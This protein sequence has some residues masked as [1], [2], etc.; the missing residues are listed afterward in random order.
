MDLP[1]HHHHDSAGW[2]V[3]G[4]NHSLASDKVTSSFQAAYTM[5]EYDDQLNTL[6]KENF[7]LKL[8]IYFMEER[9]G[10]LP[11]PKEQENI[12][13]V[14][15]D[16]KVHSEE[17]KKDL[18]EKA[19][20]LSQAAQALQSQEEKYKARIGNLNARLEHEKE[21]RVTAEK[22]SEEVRMEV[23]DLRDQKD[24]ER[25]ISDESKLLY[26]EAFGSINLGLGRCDNDA[27]K[28]E[29]IE[30][31]EWE[32]QTHEL[33]D[34]VVEKNKVISDLEL[35]NADLISK[36]REM[37]DM[38]DARYE[39]IEFKQKYEEVLRENQK[40]KMDTE[41]S[42]GIIKEFE[43]GIQDKE[44][45]IKDCNVY[46]DSLTEQLN[47]KTEE[48]DKITD[49]LQ[50]SSTIQG[51]DEEIASLQAEL[52]L[53]HDQ[54]QRFDQMEGELEKLQWFEGRVKELEMQLEKHTT[55][56]SDIQQE[57]DDK[58]SNIENLEQDLA[59]A[60]DN[61]K[62]VTDNM[63]ECNIQISGLKS[64]LEK[65]NID[66]IGFV[67]MLK[68]IKESLRNQGSPDFMINGDV[69]DIDVEATDLSWDYGI[70]NILEPTKNL[71][72][73][74]LDD[75]L[76]KSKLLDDQN[77]EDKIGHINYLNDRCTDLENILAEKHNIIAD[78]QQNVR[79][80]GEL[81]TKFDE[82]EKEQFEMQ[83]YLNT[84]LSEM[85]KMRQEL[86]VQK[87]TNSVNEAKL[88]KAISAIQGFVTENLKLSQALNTLT[89]EKEA[90]ANENQIKAKNDDVLCLEN[91]RLKA[92]VET[93][94]KENLE[95]SAKTMFMQRGI[96]KARA[97]F[98]NKLGEYRGKFDT[99]VSG[100]RA[101]REACELMRLR[102]EELADFLQQLLDM[103]GEGGDLNLSC[104]SLDMRESLQRS[105]DESRLLSASIL[106][107]Q[108]SMLQEMSM[109]GL[110]IG[111]EEQMEELNEEE[112]IVPEV[113]AS[114]F[115]DY[116]GSGESKETVSKEE[117]DSLLLELR[118]NLRKRR[119][120]EEE[121]KNMRAIME[122]KESANTEDKKDVNDGRQLNPKSKLP[123]HIASVEGNRDRSLTPSARGLGSSSVERAKLRKT[124]VG[125]GT[126]DNLGDSGVQARGRSGSRSRVRKSAEVVDGHQ[127]RKTLSKIPGP[128]FGEEEDCWSEPD[129]EES[130]RRIGL[131]SDLS[132]ST[133][134]GR[135]GG[136]SHRT[137]DDE[138]IGGELG[139]ELRRERGRVERLR[140]DLITAGRKEKELLQALETAK[141]ELVVCKGQLENS[142]KELKNGKETLAK[143]EMQS[144]QIEGESE[145]LRKELE[146]TADVE[147]E[148][149][150]LENQ[151]KQG[152]EVIE[153]LNKDIQWWEE[154][155]KKMKDEL[156]KGDAEGILQK[157]I[158]TKNQEIEKLTKGLN[159]YE[160][161]CKQMIEQYDNLTQEVKKWKEEADTKARESEQSNQE[162]KV[163]IEDIKKYENYCDKL[164]EEYELLQIE[165]EKWKGLAVEKKK[166]ED[167]TSLVNKY[168]IEMQKIKSE[169]AKKKVE[170]E[171]LKG[172]NTKLE[173]RCGDLDEILKQNDA[174]M[175]ELEEK[176]RIFAYEME[177]KDKS[178]ASKDENLS[179]AE[180]LLTELNDSKKEMKKQLESV[181]SE[182]SESKMEMQAVKGSFEK[183]KREYND[184][185]TQNKVNEIETKMKNQAEGIKKF[186]EEI[187]KIEQKSKMVE[188]EKKK[189]EEE[190]KIR[191][192][193]Q[194]A[195]EKQIQNLT[196][197]VEKEKNMSAELGKTIENLR[198]NVQK[199]E[200]EKML[201]ESLEIEFKNLKKTLEL[202]KEL[203][204]GLNDKIG[205][206]E[207]SKKLTEDR[208]LSAEKVLK[209][210]SADSFSV[211]KENQKS[212]LSKLEMETA[213][214]HSRPSSRRQG[215][216]SLDHNTS[217]ALTTSI[218][219]TTPLCC[220]HWAEL[221]Q[222]KLERDAALAKLSSTRSSLATTA[223]KLSISNRRKKQ[224]E[225]AI[226]QQLTKTHE[227]LKKTKNN[228]ENVGGDI[229]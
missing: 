193:A 142:K 46:I 106:A 189:L 34:M 91:E 158:G 70:D 149:L 16:L 5:R 172:T 99:V 125:T 134:H 212:N 218:P 40:L 122:A 21:R 9:L 198:N 11:A 211:D 152:D 87:D 128:V 119:L 103:E 194:K 79:D 58:R 12:Y 197:T 228:L 97:E 25:R 116:D 181:S 114:L 215:L 183:Y 173:E 1:D 150:L 219:S 123:V 223:E 133:G 174:K 157:E 7:N 113:E 221:E 112:W 120:A 216:S 210:I 206:L 177:R 74:L 127:R 92:E 69:F 62:T 180:R 141:K 98:G 154:W 77:Q 61:F 82:S 191:L 27:T 166:S 20:L 115:Y 175:F 208:C 14:N 160:A 100:W 51:R 131:E 54:Q 65:R 30:I 71:I 200:T 68:K 147:R 89:A 95:A 104:L 109:V 90:L 117:Y 37:G 162:I 188:N 129:K 168:E 78:L 93:L 118:D 136:H 2:Q 29:N 165:V 182:L 214:L 153:K 47:E 15:I 148:K 4:S 164:K 80:Q 195:S 108:T 107:S 6:K 145:Q 28:N 184:E 63:D 137:T 179:I 111:E 101:G 222:V 220:S 33:T 41:N 52:A 225:K 55:S 24:G 213:L 64:E 32:K 143:L 88:Q 121:L 38:K 23:K 140:G 199:L 132:G 43:K 75:N 126:K 44:Y 19:N 45:V 124:P 56:P 26:A 203:Q 190:L 178:I 94:T 161:K 13:R 85:K 229:Q 35:K 135:D 50:N 167:V 31:A 186:A 130:R 155:C 171:K 18:A 209:T 42:L 187:L 105:I 72:E 201:K 60:K 156:E 196:E 102:L 170:L 139:T 48:I 66:I 57:L 67:K 146:K 39:V 202:E 3:D 204:K 110:Q 176:V 217:S 53:H 22:E 73:K 163:L 96:E 83:T 205:K 144:Q 207:K 151:V 59:I 84:K 185:I 36:V 192:G 49:K 169:F 81:Q 76:E 86:A 224:V 8:R 227:V 159:R 226:C 17:L 138:I 10:L